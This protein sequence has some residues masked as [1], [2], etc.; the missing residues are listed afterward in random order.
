LYAGGHIIVVIKLTTH[1]P[2]TF[3]IFESEAVLENV[4]FAIFWSN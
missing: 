1:A 4:Y 3:P 2:A